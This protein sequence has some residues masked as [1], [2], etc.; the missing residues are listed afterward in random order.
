M[1]LLGELTRRRL[2]VVTGKGG[3]GKSVISGALAQLAHAAGRRV[4][5]LEAD[6][7]ETQHELAGV[8]PSGGDFVVAKPGLLI[9][10][11]QPR[12]V[13]EA[14]VREHV[15][16]EMLVRRVIQSPLFHHFVDAAPGLE[17]LAILGHAFRVL[18]G[19][20]PTPLEK[21]D[22][23]VLDAPA[24]GHSVS[25]L[26]APKV[27]AEVVDAGPFAHLAAEL[28]GFIAEPEGHR[29]RH[30]HAGGRDASPGGDRAAGAR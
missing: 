1:T 11:L 10:N 22:L 7:R 25:M 28:A 20:E 9:Q 24:T 15:R 17:E 18:Q 26:A 16:I 2:L 8:A 21:V 4:L 30:R 3:V 23:V 6:P 27:V 5:L 12:R 29:H 14:A 19:V 13:F